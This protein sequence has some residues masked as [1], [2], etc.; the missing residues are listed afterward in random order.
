MRFAD[1]SCE[2]LAAALS[3][4][5]LTACASCLSCRPSAPLKRT[6]LHSDWKVKIN[7]FHLCRIL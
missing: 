1:G 2:G 3:I 6:R 4:K 5:A 7:T